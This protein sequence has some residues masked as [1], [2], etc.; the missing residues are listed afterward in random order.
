MELDPITQVS[1]QYFPIKCGIYDQNKSVLGG[2]FDQLI[3]KV[4]EG[5][6]FGIVSLDGDCK[7]LHPD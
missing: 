5:K 2:M 7:F 6:Y 1:F 4:R 3:A